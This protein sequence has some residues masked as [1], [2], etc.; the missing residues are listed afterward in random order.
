MTSYPLIISAIIKEQQ[1][2]IGPVALERA[3]KVGGLVIKDQN[4]VSISG[5][6]KDILNNLVKEY[7]NLFGKASIE[8]CR[9]AVKEI[10]PPVPA[11]M[12][13]SILQ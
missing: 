2:I 11:D 3:K 5:D 8:V 13:P 1:Q 6:A 4:T 10:T 9:D 7:S 12:L